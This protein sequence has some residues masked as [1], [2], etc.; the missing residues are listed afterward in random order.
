MTTMLKHAAGALATLVFTGALQAAECPPGDRNIVPLD[1]EPPAYPLGAAMFC[2]E[3]TVQVRFSVTT[4]GRVDDLQIA[5]SFP[6]GVFDRE[7]LATVSGWR[8]EPACRD[9]QAISREA[10]QTLEF[11]MDQAMIDEYGCPENVDTAVAA[12]LTEIAGWYAL[13]AEWLMARPGTPI[14]QVLIPELRD[15]HVGDER[16]VFEFHRSTIETLVENSHQHSAPVLQRTLSRLLDVERI[17]FDSGLSETRALL[18]AVSRDL[19]RHAEAEQALWEQMGTAYRNLAQETR[20]DSATRAL[21]VHPFVGDPDS[22]IEFSRQQALDRVADLQ[23]LVS[24]LDEGRWSVRQGQVAFENASSQRQ[25]DSLM[26]RIE[27]SRQNLRKSL[28]RH[29]SGFS[30]FG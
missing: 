9:G 5:E 21:L 26:E 18:E 29:L 24:L 8:F 14:P 22:E 10:T 3:G 12:T 11:A 6:P 28:E 4:D 7:V 13:L 17:E 16:R 19:V 15:E 30:D 27:A 25:F 23:S 2:V 20:F 1:R